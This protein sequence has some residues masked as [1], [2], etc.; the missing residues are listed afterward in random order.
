MCFELYA[1]NK[2][3]IR[4][5][6]QGLLGAK[7]FISTNWTPYEGQAPVAWFVWLLLNQMYAQL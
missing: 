6:V 3:I 4:V 7:N 2:L 1:S 5:C